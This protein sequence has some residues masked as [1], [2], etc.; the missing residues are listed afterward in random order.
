MDGLVIRP[1]DLHHFTSA[2]G[3]HRATS[4]QGNM[5]MPDDLDTATLLRG[6]ATAHGISCGNAPPQAP[7][8]I[9]TP[10]GLT[11]N[12][13]DWAGTGDPI[14]FLHGG[15]LTCHTWD[16]VCLSLRH[17]YRCV[18][19][20]LRG[21]GESGWADDYTVA[22]YVSD[23]AAVIADF[24]WARV[25]VVGMSLGGII[26][27]HYATSSDA[28]AASLAL[29]DVAPNVDFGAVG[30]MRHFMDRPIADLSLD[31]LVDAALSAGARGGRER[32]L[33]RYRHMTWI[34]HDGRLAWRQDRTRR[35][36]YE[37]LLGKLE[38]LTGLAPAIACPVLIVRGERSRVLT[39]EK[40]AAFAARC[41]D[42]HWLAILGAGHN[43][44]EDEPLALATT[45]RQFIDR[46]APS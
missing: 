13:I 4:V 42:G 39:D 26:A 10:Q 33:Y 44:Q 34:D 41:R 21:H 27:A 28:R 38:E 19:I 29:I 15:G 46:E 16:L 45:L 20:D 8:Q 5:S 35:R 17:S 6:L 11:L 3:T 12:C 23:V 1:S 43:V 32:I 2:A 7:R 22:A 37:H 36:D 30:P 9:R 24:G 14:L 31:Q 18:A 25:H 40:V